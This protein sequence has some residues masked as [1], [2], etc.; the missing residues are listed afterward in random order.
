MS[1]ETATLL[2]RSGRSLK[3]KPLR[4]EHKR[5][6]VQGIVKRFDVLPD[7]TVH[8]K[9]EFDDTMLEGDQS[10]DDFVYQV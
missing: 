4:T 6:V 1:V 5:R 3:F 9:I 8:P 10:S 2:R 7:K